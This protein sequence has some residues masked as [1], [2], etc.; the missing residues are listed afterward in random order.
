MI[1]FVYKREYGANSGYTPTIVCNTLF[2]D[3]SESN[4]L[5]SY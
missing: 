2:K 4:T 3:D 1:L 5:L